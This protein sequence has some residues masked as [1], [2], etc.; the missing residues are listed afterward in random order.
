M[1]VRCQHNPAQ[2]RH[3]GK[4]CCIPSKDTEM[5]ALILPPL[6]H[7]HAHLPTCFGTALQMSTHLGQLIFHRS[8]RETSPWTLK[9][10]S[11]GDS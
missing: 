5:R 8:Q 1:Q 10:I 3:S 6:N 7:P 4:A 9:P 11:P 2:Q